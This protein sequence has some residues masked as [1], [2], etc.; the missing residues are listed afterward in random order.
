MNIVSAYEINHNDK[1]VVVPY[2][3]GI[4]EVNDGRGT[5][6][7]VR[8]KNRTL[9]I[10]MNEITTKEMFESL[11]SMRETGEYED[12]KFIMVEEEDHI[13]VWGSE[14]MN[15]ESSNRLIDMYVHDD[16]CLRQ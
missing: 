4:F 11:I 16:I 9:V 2:P 10:D 14:F 7:Y 13:E 1:F 5:T 8:W 15:E 3:D 12:L 6:F